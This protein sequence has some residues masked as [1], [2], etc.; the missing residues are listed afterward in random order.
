MAATPAT[1]VDPR[2][3]RTR[4]VVIR[5]TAELLVECGF[6]RLTIEAVAERS[7]VA[8]ST[9]YRNWPERADLLMTAFDRLCAFP[10][11]PDLGSLTEEL[12][13]LGR[14]LA[15]GLAT[16]AW[17]QA[18]P[19]LIGSAAH[20][21]SLVEAQRTFSRRRREL[22]G[23]VFERAA[24]RGEIDRGVD[25]GTL[26]EQFAAGF[27]FRRLIS[28]GPLDE[29]FVEHQIAAVVRAASAG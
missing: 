7:G 16:A 22:V 26:A 10:E 18:L 17:G 23:A 24:A 2:V 15:E 25:P 20:D 14:D 5:A 1:D 8:R 21:P 11:I 13:V 6:E 28:H 19:S 9:I 27:F 12:R 4:D 3:A 29:G